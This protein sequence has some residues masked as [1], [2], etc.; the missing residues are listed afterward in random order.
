ML[1]RLFDDDTPLVNTTQKRDDAGAAVE[2]VAEPA[3]E[4]S[5]A[6]TPAEEEVKEVKENESA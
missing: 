1:L 2:P 4:D 6:T 5:I 3:A